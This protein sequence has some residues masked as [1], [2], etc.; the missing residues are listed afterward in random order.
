MNSFS[1]NLALPVVKESNG[2][3]CRTPEDVH[4]LLQDT[5]P[6]AQEAFTVLTLNAKN[7]VLDRH[8]ITLGIADASLVHPREV[9]RTAIADGAC[10]I[11]LSHNHPSGD[12]TPSAED[13]RIT[14]QLVEAGRILGIEVLDH[15]IIGRPDPS[16]VQPFLSLRESGL[17]AFA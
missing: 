11:I 16:R 10:A 12:P 15:I 9:F 3:A 14:R 17:V 5:A 8:L 7:R 6:L 2:H 1:F 4:R 13:I